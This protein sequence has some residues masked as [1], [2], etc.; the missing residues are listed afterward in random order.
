MYLSE[1]QSLKHKRAVLSSLKERLHNRYNISVAE[2]AHNDLW[3]R[4]TLALAI[5]SNAGDHADSVIDKAI[6][7]IESDSRVQVIDFLVEER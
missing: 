5:V 2:V 4:S 3:Q 6:R 1:A 7:F